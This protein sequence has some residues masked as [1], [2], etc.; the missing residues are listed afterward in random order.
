MIMEYAEGGELFNY[1]IDQGCLSE[2][3]SR[4][5]FQQII[6][7]I[8]YLHQIGI[9]HR[10]LKPENILFDSKEKKKIKIIDFG[11]S[12]LYMTGSISN[13]NNISFSSRKD[14]LETPC[15]SP[16]YAPPEMILG[17]KYDGIMT[18]IWSSG[19][20]LYAMLCGCLP[21]DDFSEDKLY[22]KI[23]KGNYEYP[24]MIEIS[25]EAKNF[26]NSILI[27]NPKQRATINDIKK[28]KWF[29][30]NY[31]P[32]LGLYISIYEIPVSNLIIE[33][34][35][36]RGYDEKKIVD[37]VKNNNHNSLTTIYYLLVKQKLKKG[38]ETESDMISNKF[39][40]YIREQDT[41]Y[42]KENIRPISLKLFI[43]KTKKYFLKNKEKK[44]NKENKEDK[45]TKNER[46]KNK[47]NKNN[48]EISSRDTKE[49]IN[50]ENKIKD[51][52]NKDI[53]N[54]NKESN[55][56]NISKKKNKT[57]SKEKNHR[58]NNI[59]IN[60]I[61]NIHYININNIKA[62][63]LMKTCDSDKNKMNLYKKITLLSKSKKDGSGSNSKK[64]GNNKLNTI[65]L[66]KMKEGQFRNYMNL[67]YTKRITTSSRTKRMKKKKKIK[68]KNN[69]SVLGDSNSNQINKDF[70]I[71]LNNNENKNSSIASDKKVNKKGIFLSKGI[72]NN[73]NLIKYLKNY[74]I[75]LKKTKHVKDEY[76]L[77]LKHLQ[78]NQ[79][80]NNELIRPKNNSRKKSAK[81][82][83]NIK[84]LKNYKI[85]NLRIESIP[86]MTYLLNDFKTSRT[87]KNRYIMNSVSNSQSKSK[88][89]TGTRTS[90]SSNS[91]SKSNSTR[92]RIKKE[93]FLAFKSSRNNY[94]KSKLM[95][96]NA[97]N[98][99]VNLTQEKLSNLKYI[100]ISYNLGKDK[101]HYN[102]NKNEMNQIINTKRGNTKV[103]NSK[104]KKK[105][106][107]KPK[108]NSNNYYYKLQNFKTSIEH[109][110][111]KK[112]IKTNNYMNILIN[113]SNKKNI[114]LRHNTNILENKSINDN[115]NNFYP[116][117]RQNQSL[118]FGV[119]LNQKKENIKNSLI[120]KYTKDESFYSQNLKKYD[121][122]KRDNYKVVTQTKQKNNFQRVNLNHI[123]KNI[124]EKINFHSIK[125][126]NK[127]KE[128]N[129]FSTINNA[130]NIQDEHSNDFY[131]YLNNLKQ[132]AKN[133]IN[134]ILNNA[135]INKSNNKKI[136]KKNIKLGDLK[137]F[138]IK[139]LYAYQD[140]KPQTYRRNKKYLDENQYSN[141]NRF[142]ENHFLY[143][144]ANLANNSANNG[145]LKK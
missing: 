9:C 5:I 100:K 24:P 45:E 17:C 106:I 63:V 7:A 129:K 12:N 64:K 59:N 118:N 82:N 43:L 41:K 42:K 117:S 56:K 35:K 96:K 88:S 71:S 6:D 37:N 30:K 116:E 122:T 18:D 48:N 40:N 107:S 38:I 44:K 55:Y 33:E 57:T 29:L 87:G 99:R 15:G 113:D 72:N 69:K 80:K 79:I 103:T 135:K 83:E 70:N 32:S 47:D 126:Y 76:S 78:I 102:Q 90:N 14:L 3:E 111:L 142:K 51:N 105:V 11:L 23:I 81:D 93:S 145:Y 13:N 54:K 134:R 19:I 36:K 39:H 77:G 53:D 137:S 89:K 114:I 73:N 144:L 123:Q 109:N 16:G 143:S 130:S 49:N 128:Y 91:K 119:N 74:Q 94:S 25:D 22:S 68:I 2:D 66:N 120:K 112:K 104:S 136:S 46:N 125:N 26:I 58:I 92:D 127:F 50:K 98:R 95:N 86:K 4:Y 67:Q 124:K 85:K 97:E 139:N 121:Q 52:K 115:S 60:N 133:K 62:N 20:I 8:N 132:S 27:V 84:S 34:M 1:I 31:K 28:N 65:N 21:F 110:K 108:N 141:D 75:K 138:H 140:I 61:K 101:S 131:Y 10:D